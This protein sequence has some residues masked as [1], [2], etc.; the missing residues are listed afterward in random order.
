MSLLSDLF[1]QPGALRRPDADA[2]LAALRDAL[3]SGPLAL[4]D[5]AVPLAE[6]MRQAE[7]K[8]AA[9]EPLKRTAELIALAQFGAGSLGRAIAGACGAPADAPACESLLVAEFLVSVAAPRSGVPALVPPDTAAGDPAAAWAA[10]LD[11]AAQALAAAEVPGADPGLRRFR[12][13]RAAY[14]ARRIARLRLGHPT[15]APGLRDRIAVA[16]AL[17]LGR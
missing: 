16:L 6:R 4:P 14:C 11:R 1:P 13:R 10:L 12:R 15:G 17:L 7:A 8:I 9:G 5:W 2:V 3:S